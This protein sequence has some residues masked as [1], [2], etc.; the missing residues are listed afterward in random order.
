MFSSLNNLKDVSFDYDMGSVCG[1]TEDE[2]RHNFGPHLVQYAAES[3]QS[4]DSVIEFM[5]T[6]YNGYKFGYAPINGS[7]STSVYNPFAICNA[8]QSFDLKKDFW[9]QSG[10]FK[11]LAKYLK[12]VSALNFGIDA[13]ISIRDLCKSTTQDSM[14]LVP[15]MYYGGGAT[16]KS[17]DATTYTV[18]LEIPNESVRNDLN[19]DVFSALFPDALENDTKL[20]K[21]IDDMKKL[22]TE[23]DCKLE[24]T[25]N[26]LKGLFNRI[27]SY[28]PYDMLKDEGSCCI[29]LVMTLRLAFNQIATEVHTNHGRIDMVLVIPENRVFIFEFKYNVSVKWAIKQIYE[30]R[31]IEPYIN[32]SIPVISVGVNFY[33]EDPPSANKDGSTDENKGKSKK[34]KSN[35]TVVDMVMIVTDPSV[36]Y[37]D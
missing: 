19:L 28:T 31:Y 1:F 27:L 3:N 7:I 36:K 16:L 29:P 23:D 15:L 13:P 18:T 33:K 2:I 24:K 5:R 34:V 11:I 12:S 8:M 14:S 37:L 10:S 9:G 21:I 26:E 17:Y 32:Q 4:V 20:T 25:C 22:L 30:K 6:R 35:R